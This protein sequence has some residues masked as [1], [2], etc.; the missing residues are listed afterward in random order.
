[1]PDLQNKQ[2]VRF[3]SQLLVSFSVRHPKRPLSLSH[4]HTHNCHRFYTAKLTTSLTCTIWTGMQDLSTYL[5]L[6]VLF[7]M[8][9][10]SS[11]QQWIQT[12]H[13]Q[14]TPTDTG[15]LYQSS[16]LD[17]FLHKLA[18]V[19]LNV[20]VWPNGMFQFIPYHHARA[21]RAC[22]SNE[23]HDSCSSIWVGALK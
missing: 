5:G 22:P 8:T 11:S 21:L 12:I 2:L 6:Q 4:T 23:G 16:Y 13:V 15:W 20:M 17:W 19:F 14:T 7:T 18:I 3:T 10:T 9:R 1:M